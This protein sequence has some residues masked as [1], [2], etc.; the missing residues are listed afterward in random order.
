MA[1]E[2]SERPR[3]VERLA[4]GISGL[5]E[6]LRGGLLRDGSY[7]VLGEPGTGKTTLGNQVAYHHGA[8][9]GVA[10][11]V[12]VLAEAHD[13]MLLHLRGF[14]FFDPEQVGHQVHYLSLADELSREGLAGGLTALR[15]LVHEYRA[16]LLIVDG[17]SRLEDFAAS[18]AEYRRLS[19]ELHAQL[20][21]LD[22]TALLL[23]QPGVETDALHTLGTHVD[24]IVTVDDRNIGAHPARLMRV[25]KLRGSDT[26]RG[27]HEF[28]ITSAG[29]EV[30][31]R[32]EAAVMPT[33]QRQRVRQRRHAFGIPGLDDMVLGGVLTG[34]TT[35][36]V[37]PPGIG[38]TTAGLHF[39]A[40]GAHNGERG[41]IFGFQ[42]PPE[43]LVTKAD[44]L[45][46]D[47]GSQVE[48]GRVQIRWE[49]SADRPMDSWAGELLAAVAE[50]RPRRLLIDAFTDVA[51]LGI[52][53]E[54]LPAFTAALTDAL[55][56]RGATTVLTAEV[57]TVEG[58]ELAVPLPEASAM[59][60]NAILF[61]YVE[62]RSRLHR[63]VSVLRVRES[64]F[65]AS[66]REYAISDRGIEVESTSETAEAVLVDAA[67]LPAGPGVASVRAEAAPDES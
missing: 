38:K 18:R 28:A 60:D 8:N 62:P 23:A 25:L 65:D 49:P 46:L 66:V 3:V 52:V 67:R 58:T 11:Y 22:C 9:G 64:G 53:P 39:I 55:R 2:P 31:P 15:R 19:S 56:V 37:G 35:L 6:I 29:I 12:T 50:Q 26:L 61:R 16:T 36:L 42:E 21:L 59:L 51:R 34:S 57:P 7:L 17:A 4:T 54:R 5:D 32:L 27:H 63:L 44:G 33:R 48:A 30:Y 20:A 1:E 24:G 41:L 45:G 47:L 43:R 14:D 13:R 40:E 10:L